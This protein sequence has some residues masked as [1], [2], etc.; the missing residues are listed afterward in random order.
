MALPRCD[1]WPHAV[2]TPIR[3]REALLAGQGVTLTPRFVVH[4]LLASGQLQE[5][6]PQHRAPDLRIHGVVAQP[7]YTPRKV[8][9]FLDYLAQQIAVSTE[10]TAP[11]AASP[12]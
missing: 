9:V 6:L 1:T 12:Q 8:Q 11:A 2:K 7:R 10:F 5:L 3:L 4:D